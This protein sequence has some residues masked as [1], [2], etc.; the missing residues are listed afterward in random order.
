MSNKKKALQKRIFY[1]CRKKGHIANQCPKINNLKPI[2]I[3]ANDMLGK[4]GIGTS[5][6]AIFKHSAIY[7][8]RGFLVCLYSK[9]RGKVAWL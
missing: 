2:L 7:N 3:D 8:S 5:L 1:L 9:T 6:M 4:N